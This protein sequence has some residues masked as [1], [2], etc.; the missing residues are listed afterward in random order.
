MLGA[1]HPTLEFKI[2]LLLNS[3]EKEFGSLLDFGVALMSPEL[4]ELI[5]VYMLAQL[6][7]LLLHSI[8]ESEVLFYLNHISKWNF[9]SC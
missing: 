6:S 3:H 7:C 4:K 2:L 5:C 8:C 1:T 9:I